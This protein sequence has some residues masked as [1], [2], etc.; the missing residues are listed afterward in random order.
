MWSQNEWYFSESHWKETRESK[1]AWIFIWVYEFF[2]PVES[3]S[4]TLAPD[5]FH[6]GGDYC[7]YDPFNEEN[8]YKQKSHS[9]LYSV[10]LCC[11]MKL[12]FSR[13]TNSMQ[14]PT[15][16]VH[17]VLFLQ[18]DI[19]SNASNTIN[20]VLIIQSS[21]LTFLNYFRNIVNMLIQSANI[22]VIFRQLIGQ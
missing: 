5:K 15:L 7:T 16:V 8:T 4:A 20:L 17:T 18:S 13:T 21:I 2:F 19:N 1:A 22:T 12:S 6:R 10:K 11:W 14:H 9:S 3:L